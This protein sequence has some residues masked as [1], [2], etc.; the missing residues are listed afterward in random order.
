[1]LTKVV[2]ALTSDESNAALSAKQGKILNDKIGCYRI[3]YYT[4]TNYTPTDIVVDT[5]A[6]NET[7]K[8]RHLYI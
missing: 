3:I 2:D 8:R 5:L 6:N 4:T 1:M 7:N